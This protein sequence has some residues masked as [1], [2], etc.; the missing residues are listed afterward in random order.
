MEREGGKPAAVVAVVT[1]PRFAQRYREYLEKEKLLNRQHRVK[2]MPDG[3]VALPVLG[4]A[5]PEQHLQ[6]LRNRVA[7]GSTCT[8]AQLLDP[9]PSKKAQSC[10]PAQRL[11]LQQVHGKAWKTQILHIQPVKSY[12]PHVDHIVLD[13]ECR[14][15]PLVG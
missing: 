12:A 6:E 8:L 5:L 9:V 13:L 3:T 10:S 1:E 14:P 7:P 11:C 2:T 15:C 4:E